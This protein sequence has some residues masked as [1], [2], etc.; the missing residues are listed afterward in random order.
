MH[1]IRV[2]IKVPVPRLKLYKTYFM[3]NTN[4]LDQI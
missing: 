4:I 1:I 2:D 3:Q